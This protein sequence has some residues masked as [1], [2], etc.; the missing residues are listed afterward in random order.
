MP[1]FH[2]VPLIHNE[3]TKLLAA[4]VNTTAVAT[5]IA[6]VIAPMAGLFYGSSSISV[7]AWW[8][9]GSAL[10]LLVGFALHLVAQVVLGRLRP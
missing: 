8:V 5:I 3:R 7:G 9:F 4:A 1:A 10:W 6:G 2:P